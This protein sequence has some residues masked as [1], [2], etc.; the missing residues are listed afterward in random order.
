[1]KKTI[2]EKI[3]SRKIKKPGI[4]YMVLGFIWKKF[5]FKKYNIRV[6]N[7]IDKKKLKESHIFI[8]N[9]ASRLDYIFCGLPLYPIKYNFVAGYNEFHRSHLAKVFKM[10]RIIPKKNFVPD[11]YTIRQVS[12]ILNKNG[13]IFIFPEGMSSISGENQPVAIGTGKFIKHFQKPVFYS[14]IKGGYLTSPKYNLKERKGYIEVVFDQ[15]FTVEQIKDL[16]PSEI[17]NIINKKIYQ[18]DYKWNI[19]HKHHYDIKNEGALHLEDLLYHCPK[20]NRDDSMRT[21]ENKIFCTNC[22]NGAQI[23]DTY[24]LIPFDNKCV[25]P[26]TQTEWFKLQRKIMKEKIK[27]EDFVLKEKVKLGIL[28][29]YKLLKNQNTSKIVEEGW[30]ILNR[31]GLTYEGKNISFNIPSQSLPTYGMCTDVSRIYTFFDGEYYEFYPENNMVAKFLLATEE[32][33]RINKGKWQE[34]KYIEK[35]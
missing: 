1:M 3:R 26:P 22:G 21:F 11:V 6:I 2:S 34:F 24:E 8:S 4:V 29:K 5:V 14:V 7:H 31:E 20:C 12:N 18:D 30:L 25:I 16:T 28:P 10:L 9:H 15:L 35:K 13:N 19:E 23:L 33:H 17:E 32:I 27:Q